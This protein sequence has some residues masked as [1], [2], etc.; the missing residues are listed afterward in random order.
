MRTL[1][2]KITMD[3]PH[4][5]D[6]KPAPLAPWLCAWWDWEDTCTVSKGFC[7]RPD[8]EERTC[9]TNGMRLK[10]RADQWIAYD[11][12]IKWLWLEGDIGYA[13]NHDTGRWQKV[14]IV[15]NRYRDAM[16]SGLACNH[17]ITVGDLHGVGR[18]AFYC[19]DCCQMKRVI[20]TGDK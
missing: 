16:C 7:S 17:E 11:T 6:F 12:L 5:P 3:N 15:K 4:C 2:I 9:E 20:P 1:K 13:R 8:W 10:A 19:L 14:K 18:N